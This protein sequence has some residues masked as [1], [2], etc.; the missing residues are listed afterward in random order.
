MT[1]PTTIFEFPVTFEDEQVPP[2]LD[3]I[4]AMLDT[5]EAN[6]ENGAP[7]V[8]L[9]HS[10]NSTDKLEAERRILSRLPKDILVENMTEYAR[11][12]KAR[13]QVRWFPRPVA[14]GEE[15]EID[16]E[17]PIAGLTL[18]T[19]RRIQNAT[20]MPGMRWTDHE[21]ILPDLV[22]QSRVHLHIDYF[23]N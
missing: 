4:P 21:V 23:R 3:R 12:W 9:I 14:G 10:N 6:A 22:G 1:E 17:L 13:S 16:A 2:L 20:G 7:S 18:V 5:I 8:I 15:V 11:F 19:L